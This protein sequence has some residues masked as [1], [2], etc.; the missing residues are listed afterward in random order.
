MNMLKHNNLFTELE[1]DK[2]QFKQDLITALDQLVP[3]SKNQTL[4]EL[5][6][7]AEKQQKEI[8]DHINNRNSLQASI[9]EM[10]DKIK[11]L[12]E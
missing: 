7:I 4:D 8:Q 5:L 12:N 9:R 11:V 3:V 6:S 10:T 1:S 2:E